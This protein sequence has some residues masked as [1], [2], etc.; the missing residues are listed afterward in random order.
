MR[1][2][3]PVLI[4]GGHSARPA[5]SHSHGIGHLHFTRGSFTSYFNSRL[6]C[7]LIQKEGLYLIGSYV[8][9]FFL[10]QSCG[11][12][13]SIPYSLFCYHFFRA[14]SRFKGGELDQYIR[15]FLPTFREN[16]G[17]WFIY[18]SSLCCEPTPTGS[19]VEHDVTGLVHPS[20][21]RLHIP[22]LSVEDPTNTHLTAFLSNFPLDGS[23][24]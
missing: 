3:P 2:L 18:V 23:G 20:C 4:F 7:L 8:G 22:P 17:C 9:S 24:R 5:R 13:V 6:K 14:G 1:A 16:C 12:E 15:V 11:H 19:F 21:R 10:S